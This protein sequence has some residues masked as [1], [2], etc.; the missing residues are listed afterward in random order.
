MTPYECYVLYLALKKHF[1]SESYD[2]FKY[3]GKIR[4]SRDSFE[5]RPD[6]IFFAKL[7]KKED[8]IG[9]LV[10]NFIDNEKA[11]I[12]ELAYS[13]PAQNRYQEWMKKKQS[14]SYVFKQDLKKL[15]PAFDNNLLIKENSHPNLLRLFLSK[16]IC[17]ETLAIL[18]TVSGCKQYWDKSM[19]YDPVWEHVSKKIMKYIPFLKLDNQ[20]YSKIVVETFRKG[21]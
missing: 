13:E 12:K 15:D 11:W 2:Y 21:A 5:A 1:T 18:V 6:K 3:N 17:I 7:S 16:E 19:S 10:A 20:K 14:L 4:A 8:P 9:F